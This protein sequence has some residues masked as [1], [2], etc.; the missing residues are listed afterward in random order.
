MKTGNINKI[1]WN[2]RS[3]A[4]AMLLWYFLRRTLIGT[5]IISSESKNTSTKPTA[6]SLSAHGLLAL[7]S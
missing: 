7:A 3:D 5:L 4:A 6:V 1:L 2:N